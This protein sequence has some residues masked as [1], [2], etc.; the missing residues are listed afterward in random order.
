MGEFAVDVVLNPPGEKGE[1]LN[2]P[3]HM[4]VGALLLPQLQARR[5]LRIT[6]GKGRSRLSQIGQLLGIV[7]QE[8]VVFGRGHSRLAIP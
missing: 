2:Q 3:F 5:D 7:V 4:G 8:D 1:G 6:V